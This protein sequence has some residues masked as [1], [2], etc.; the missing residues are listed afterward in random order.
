ME[1]DMTKAP[2]TN[3]AD[4]NEDFIFEDLFDNSL[5]TSNDHVAV[6]FIEETP[7]ALS[8][9]SCICTPC[10]SYHKGTK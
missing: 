5:F 8:G 6:G 1:K 3:G 10:I 9:K 4:L 7:A 2:I